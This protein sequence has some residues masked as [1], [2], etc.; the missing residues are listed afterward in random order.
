[1]AERKIVQCRTSFIAVHGGRQVTIMSGD[2]YY[3]DD[4][5]VKGREQHFG[6]LA[7]KSSTPAPAPSRAAETATAAPGARRTVTKPPAKQSKEGGSD[8]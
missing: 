1:M 5:I 6:E 8:A 3:A 4:P 2:L 7:V